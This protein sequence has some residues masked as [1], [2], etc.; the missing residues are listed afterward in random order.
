MQR[1]HEWSEANADLLLAASGLFACIVMPTLLL[2]F[3]QQEIFDLAM[4]PLFGAVGIGMLASGLRGWTGAYS[5]LSDRKVAALRTALITLGVVIGASALIACVIGLLAGIEH[6]WI[7]TSQVMG[8]DPI[9][10]AFAALGAMGGF[11]M[12]TRR[13]PP[14]EAKIFWFSV[15]GGVV[16]WCVAY[17]AFFGVLLFLAVRFLLPQLPDL[18]RGIASQYTRASA[19]PVDVNAERIAD[20]R[21]QITWVLGA[22]GVPQHFKDEEI[23]RLQHEIRDL[24]GNA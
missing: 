8:F 4:L 10:F 17:F 22:S 21:Q 18:Y 6:I 15:G 5:T 13:P 9:R 14:D 7:Q 1:L 19:R 24:G 3:A 11:H 12:A 2:Q 16:G 20:L 23:A